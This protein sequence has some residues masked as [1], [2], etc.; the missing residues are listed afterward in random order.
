[1]L[2]A[3]RDEVVD[4]R[5][6][7]ELPPGTRALD[8]HLDGEER[9]VLDRDAD[10]L[11]RRHEH[12]S[13]RILAQHRGEELYERRPADRRAVVEPGAVGGDAHVDLAAI[14]R[15]PALD[16]GRPLSAAGGSERGAQARER[17]SARW[18]KPRRFLPHGENG[19]G[20]RIGDD[21]LAAVR[22]QSRHHIFGGHDR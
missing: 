9:R 15:L 20:S 21:E 19:R 16:R 11:D 7:R 22:R 17:V 18:R 14:G 3:G 8:R 1:M 2:G 13:L 12:E 5:A 10:A 4:V 6:E